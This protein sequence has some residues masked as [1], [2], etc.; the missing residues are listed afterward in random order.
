MILRLI[1]LLY[2]TKSR[3]LKRSSLTTKQ[4]IG[5][6]PISQNLCRVLVYISEL[7]TDCKLL[8]PCLN[9]LFFSTSVIHPF[10]KDVTFNSLGN[11][12][13]LAASQGHQILRTTPLVHCREDV[14]STSIPARPVKTASVFLKIILINVFVDPIQLFTSGASSDTLNLTLKTFSI[15]VSEYGTLWPTY[16]GSSLSVRTRLIFFPYYITCQTSHVQSRA[17]TL[18]TRQRLRSM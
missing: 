7:R 17:V 6:L 10:A 9:R 3:I 11:I 1:F 5:Q 14:F 15:R 2:Y 16:Q 4:T 13:A 8:L 12:T 18:Y